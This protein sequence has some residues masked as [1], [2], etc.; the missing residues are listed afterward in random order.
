MGKHSYGVILDAGSS[1]TRVY[2]YNWKTAANARASDSASELQRLPEI[3]TKKKWRKKVHPGVST[4]G[5]KPE[6]VGPEHLKELVEFALEIVPEDEVEKTPIFLLATAGMRLLPELQRAEVLENICGYFQR[7]T[8]FQLPDCG[9]HVQVIP[10]ETEGLYGWIAANYLLGGFDAPGEHEHGNGHHTYG[11]LDMGGAS[12]QIAFAPNATESEK[13]AEDLKLLRLRKVNGENLEHKVFVTTWLGFGANEAR[14]RYVEGLLESYPGSKELPD[15]CLPVGLLAAISGEELDSDSPA[16]AGNQPHLIGTGQFPEC[17]KRTYPLLEKDMP[18]EDEPCLLNGIHT[19][20]IDFQVNHFVGVSE[21][22]HTT[23]EIFA[24][25]HKDKAYDFQTYQKQVTELCSRD[26][27]DIEE[28]IEEEK[29]GKKVDEKTVEEVCFKASW[30]IN[31]LHDGIGVPRVGL[32]TSKEI[33]DGS[34]NGTHS[35]IDGAKDRGFLDPFQAIDKVDGTEV[36]WTLGK[37]VLYASSQMP[38]AENEVLAVGFGSNTPGLSLPSDF[39]Y[40]SSNLPILGNDTTTSNVSSQ[41]WHD[42]LLNSSYSRRAPGIL[43]FLLILALAAYLLCGRDRRASLTSKFLGRNSGSGASKR[44]KPGFSLSSKLF[45]SSSGPAYERVLEAGAEDSDSEGFE[46]GTMSDDSS[47][48]RPSDP[49]DPPRTG[50]TSGWATPANRGLSPD[51]SRGS[52]KHKS[53]FDGPAAA[54][55]SAANGLGITA[56]ER[57]GLV[58]RTESKEKL[59]AASGAGAGAGGGGGGGGSR[60]SR[61]RTPGMGARTPVLTPFKVGMD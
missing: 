55:G 23:H 26:W 36:S 51:F 11:F 61:S 52:P 20:A 49:I 8:K 47:A 2:V 35:V 39:Q 3:K 60:T 14:R 22:W 44:P 50:R 19:P 27:K 41:D 43:I 9:L 59:H 31:M 13:H 42:R 40:P 37:M 38:A 33:A 29:W 32:E 5:E 12:A 15:P 6:E 48:T 28:D 24:M 46:L 4:F 1:G 56:F 30:L 16:L 10:G 58:V 34:T 54:A 53:Y 25:A 45:G 7:E 17:L 18:C 57:G 21:Y